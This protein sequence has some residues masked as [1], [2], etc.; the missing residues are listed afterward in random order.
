MSR[1]G[2]SAVRNIRPV[3]RGP[4]RYETHEVRHMLG[5]HHRSLNMNPANAGG[6]P[7]L[8]G[9]RGLGGLFSRAGHITDEAQQT[10]SKFTE[11]SNITMGGTCVMGTFDPGD[12]TVINRVVEGLAVELLRFRHAVELVGDGVTRLQ[13]NTQLGD[14]LDEQE[15]R[16]RQLAGAGVMPPFKAIVR[17]S[18]AR[19]AGIRVATIGARCDPGMSWRVWEA[20]AW[21]TQRLLANQEACAREENSANSGVRLEDLWMVSY[22]GDL[23]RLARYLQR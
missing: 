6:A 5:L 17:A 23:Q 19:A 8:S 20:S 18:T 1:G 2:R 9:T 21:S 22:P 10:L 16:A 11:A 15:S 13:H 3:A 12:A 7:N 4:L 14:I